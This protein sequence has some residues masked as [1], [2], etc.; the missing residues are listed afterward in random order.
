ML[1]LDSDVAVFS[2]PYPHLHGAFRR[3]ALVAAFDTKGGFANVNVGIVYFNNATVGGPVHSI[4]LE[5]ER[6]VEAALAMPPPQKV[7]H[8]CSR[9]AS[10]SLLWYPLGALSKPSCRCRT[11]RCPASS[12]TRTSS[13]RPSSPP[14]RTTP[15]RCPTPPAGPF[16]AVESGRA[17]TRRSCA[18]SETSSRRGGGERLRRRPACP[19]A[20]RGSRT[21][22]ST[23]TG[24]SAVPLSAPTRLS[25]GR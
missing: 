23:A 11:A 12:G 3:F 21:V 10:S 24:R 18:G 16:S 5:M 15:S 6:R 2:S 13:T 20:R 14:W 9:P 8:S 1:A 7:S 25:G 4:M 19:S 22:R 17:P